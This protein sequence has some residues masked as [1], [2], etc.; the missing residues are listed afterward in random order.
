MSQLQNQFIRIAKYNHASLNQIHDFLNFKDGFEPSLI[1]AFISPFMDFKDCVSR[2]KQ[3]AGEIPFIAVM[4]AGELCQETGGKGSLYCLDE[5]QGTVVIQAFDKKLISQVSVHAV[6]LG[7]EDIRSGNIKIDQSKRISNIAE[8]C[9]KI[10][11]GF[12]ICSHSTFGL[13]FVDGLSRSENYLLEALYSTRK[14]PCMFIG[15]SSG[16]KLDFQETFIALNGEIVPD[17]AVIA[18]CKMANGKRFSPFKT[19]SVKAIES[20]SCI[21]VEASSEAREIHTVLDIDLM[22]VLPVQ[23]QLCRYLECNEENLQERLQGHGLGILVGNELFARSISSV[24]QDRKSI[25]VYCDVNVGDVIYFTKEENFVQNTFDDLQNFLEGKP[26]P[27]G[28]MLNDCILRRLNNQNE[29]T[30]LDDLFDVPVA[31]FST[32]G[33]IFGI[34]INNTLSALFFFDV[35]D[36]REFYDHYMTNFCIHYA[37]YM[38]FYSERKLNRDSA[39]GYLRN[40]IVRD[41]ANYMKS[42]NEISRKIE[43]SFEDSTLAGL[44]EIIKENNILLERTF[45]IKDVIDIVVKLERSD[46]SVEIISSSKLLYETLH[47]N[48]EQNFMIFDYIK[49]LDKARSMAEQASRAKSDF[50]ANMS[51]EIRTPLNAILGMSGLLMDTPLD[52]EQK[53]WVRAVKSSGDSLLSIINDIIDISKIEAGKLV[54][55]KTDFDLCEALEEV[56]NLYA[57]QAREKQIEMMMD[58]D[59]DLPQFVIGDPVRIKQVFANLIS[60]ALKFTAKGHVFVRVKKGSV[61]NKN[62]FGVIFSVE[63]TGIGVPKE[64]QAR[65]FEKFTQAEESTTRKYG[66]TGLGLTI[67]TQLVRIMGGDIKL[68]SDIGRGSKFIFDVL[69]EESTKDYENEIKSEAEICVLAVDDY[70]LTRSLV[71]HSLER[72]NIKCDT[73]ESAEK[74]LEIL[75]NN[76]EKYDVCVTD[77]A[78]DGMN[79][80]NFIE[81][82]R[83]NKSFDHLGLLM[84]SGVMEHYSYDELK[85]MGLNGYLKKPFQTY[86]LVEAVK[87]IGIQAKEDNLQSKFV[88]RHNVTKVLDDEL[89]NVKDTHPQFPNHYVLAVDDMAMNMM[90]IRKVLSKFGLR[91]DTAVNGIEAFNKAKENTYDL[92]FMDCQMPEMDGFEATVK[93]RA[94]EKEH[95]K[96]HV[97][98]VA[99]TADAMVGDKEK[100]LS[101]GMDDY[102]NKPFKE[103]DIKNAL[104]RWLK[105]D[106]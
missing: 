98:I 42:S 82:I 44:N 8:N 85:K 90:L 50:L 75:E 5:E 104:E 52:A 97:P 46:N 48:I 103:N 76:P 74:A 40:I 37:S 36:D 61:K 65:I 33:E 87:I 77:Y 25:N 88:T 45:D 19:Q 31:G 91:I 60:N 22:E 28:V 57:Y 27:L 93:I 3:S 12:Q 72:R 43:D 56:M 38:N 58:F 79:G 4:S 13:T 92:I 89:N 35:G 80:I 64:K 99:I 53:E 78:L 105:K 66:G 73:V 17:C 101:F 15:G 81:K 47:R 59:L 69:L 30:G 18:F 11:P 41:V 10:N 68:E 54:L 29:L 102:I 106:H 96:N 26:E 62:E 51:H 71:A 20:K 84:I 86:Q 2:I 49:S 23:R 1:L 83:K 32:F 16:G 55:E 21:V 95:N 9:K 7:S 34:N 39:I 67:V 94:H 70:D 100:C 63:D 24:N 6:P 14:F